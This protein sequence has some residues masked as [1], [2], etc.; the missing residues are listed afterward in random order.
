MSRRIPLLDQTFGN[1]NQNRN[2]RGF[3]LSLPQSYSEL[4]HSASGG[5]AEV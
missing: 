1:E 3:V 2:P 4:A 5:T